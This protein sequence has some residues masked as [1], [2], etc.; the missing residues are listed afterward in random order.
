MVPSDGAPL[1][2]NRGI[3]HGR[4]QDGKCSSSLC[5]VHA[6]FAITMHNGYIVILQYLTKNAP[7]D[8]VVIGN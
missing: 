8:L 5:R 1:Y 2:Q 4:V 6:H 3:L 7:L